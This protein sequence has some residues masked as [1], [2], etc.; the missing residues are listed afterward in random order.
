MQGFPQ[1]GIAISSDGKDFRIQEPITATAS[2]NLM[3]WCRPGA[4]WPSCENASDF[5]IN[6]G[7]LQV[8]GPYESAK[9]QCRRGQLCLL[10]GLT[11]IGLSAGDQL[12][13]LPQA[14]S[15]K[16]AQKRTVMP[17][18]YTSGFLDLNF[19]IG[20]SEPASGIGGNFSFGVL[21]QDHHDGTHTF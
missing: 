19:S 1:N 18:L 3:C 8:R 10:D 6:F 2:I 14:T 13:I 17:T 15:S 9:F 7:I 12:L 21:P 20:I 16:C 11:G 5:L 4:G